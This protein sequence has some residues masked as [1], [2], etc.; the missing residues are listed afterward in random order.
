VKAIA[1][2]VAARFRVDARATTDGIEIR[3]DR[4]LELTGLAK[5]FAD[6]GYRATKTY[7]DV[8]VRYQLVAL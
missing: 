6:H 8:G 1:A 5:L 2:A 3:W 7:N 4:D